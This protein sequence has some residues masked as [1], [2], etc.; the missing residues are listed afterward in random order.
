MK[1]FGARPPVVAAVLTLAFTA[2]ALADVKEGQPAPDVNLPATQI[3]KV[4]PD[5]KDAKTLN[6]K[7]LQSKKNVVLF[8]FPKALT[9]G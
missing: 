6:L 3:A 9:G 8:F 5:Q 7:D 2:A 1:R 4:L